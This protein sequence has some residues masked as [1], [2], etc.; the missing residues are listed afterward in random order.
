MKKGFR[1]ISILAVFAVVAAIFFIGGCS[2]DSSGDG[3]FFP[4][5][6]VTTT[7]T[8]ETSPTTTTSPLPQGDPSMTLSCTSLD[9]GTASG[10]ACALTIGNTGTGELQVNSLAINDRASVCFTSDTQ[11]PFTVTPGEQRNV[12]ITFCATQ[13]QAYSADLL[14]ETNDPAHASA[15]VALTGVIPNLY[16]NPS[17]GDDANDGLSPDTAKQT[18]GD[19]ITAADPGDTIYLASGTYTEGT[20]SAGDP[21]VS[22][23]K[24]VTLIGD[25]QNREDRPII[26]PAADT[27]SGNSGNMDRPRDWCWIIVEDGVTLNV[28]NVIFDGN[29]HNICEAVRFYGEGSLKNCVIRN[30][31]H[32][33]QYIGMGLKVGN[34]VTLES[35]LFTNIQRIGIF[36]S[37][38]GVL[39]ATD[40]DFTG[41]GAGDWLDY[42]VE[43]GRGSN[44]TLTRCSITNCT[45]VALSDGSGS[46]G[47]YLHTLSM[48]YPTITGVSTANI[49]D[50][51]ITGN[52]DGI[53]LG[54]NDS[55]DGSTVNVTN[56]D[57][58]GNFEYG[59]FTGDTN[60][61]ANAANNW[62]GDASGPSG[63]GPGT[64]DAVSVNVVFDPWLTEA[65]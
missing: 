46:A 10:N 65:P 7:V 47:V 12:T 51:T 61:V 44:A 4:S 8:P 21:L 6:T 15:T 23:T 9:F 36:V 58:S 56:S 55:D 60:P 14:L 25:Y 31:S 2:T 50:C 32:S 53:Y 37:F 1:A 40:C 48:W 22:I 45:G 52:S 13:K 42:A 26:R 49:T 3:M 43:V 18:I 62:W 24:N 38:D 17:T 19:A 41:K 35:C 30:I 34:N 27:T 64:G 5:E 57:I 39:T 11:A 54:Y 29:G 28:E 16:V 20:A 33:S 63:E 59:I